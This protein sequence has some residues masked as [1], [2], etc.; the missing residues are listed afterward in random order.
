MVDAFC[1]FFHYQPIIHK[2]PSSD[3]M[4]VWEF[5]D[6]FGVH[7]ISLCHDQFTGRRLLHIDGRAE[8]TFN[9]RFVLVDSGT[10]FEFKIGEAKSSGSMTAFHAPPTRC[11][12][13]IVEQGLQFSYGL[14]INEL[15]FGRARDG[16]WQNSSMFFVP[17]K[18]FPAQDANDDLD[19]DAPLPTPSIPI[20]PV[21]HSYFT[22]SQRPR[23]YTI[24]VSAT[25]GNNNL[26]VIVDGQVVVDVESQFLLE[27]DKEEF[28]SNHHV[29]GGE[30][31]PQGDCTVHTFQ[32][33][34][35]ASSSCT[36]PSPLKCELRMWLEDVTG[37]GTGTSDDKQFGGRSSP[38]ASP[39]SRQRRRC[40]FRLKVD[41]V[42]VE[43]EPTPSEKCEQKSEGKNRNENEKV[44]QDAADAR[45]EHE[46]R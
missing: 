28:E 23:W 18:G 42:I 41:G 37:T 13:S 44:C 9:K 3:K 30:S 10:K 6:S 43:A 36:T 2:A 24:I 39:S 31:Q 27:E 32:L 34:R 25:P 5:F 17:M 7:R 29:T 14:A 8:D 21:V 11:C 19:F 1:S 26:T 16:I 35:E 12:L 33:Q 45:L 40:R 20:P 38:S 22:F 15:S 46:P 4:I